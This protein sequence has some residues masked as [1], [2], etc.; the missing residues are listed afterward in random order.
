MKTHREQFSECEDQGFLE[1]TIFKSFEDY[2]NILPLFPNQKMQDAIVSGEMN[3]I[4][5]FECGR[6][7]GECSSGHIDCQKMRSI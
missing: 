4:T 7:G 6:F 1:K 2:P 3:G 5:I